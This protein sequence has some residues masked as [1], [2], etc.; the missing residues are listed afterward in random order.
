MTGRLGPDQIELDQPFLKSPTQLLAERGIT[1]EANEKTIRGRSYERAGRV[2]EAL[3]GAS[4]SRANTQ[5]S[6]AR[7]VRIGGGE[8]AKGPR[9]ADRRSRTGQ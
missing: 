8:A 2:G 9:Q 4:R 6:E 7:V 1:Q 3:G 5:T